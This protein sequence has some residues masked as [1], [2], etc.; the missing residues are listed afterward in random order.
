MK[1]NPNYSHIIYTDRTTP[2]TDMKR[3]EGTYK[4]AQIQSVQGS[5]DGKIGLSATPNFCVCVLF[6][7]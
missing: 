6:A 7:C 4:M 5:S 1:N 3:I 2:L